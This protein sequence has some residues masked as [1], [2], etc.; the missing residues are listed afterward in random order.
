M[1]SRKHKKPDLDRREPIRAFGGV[2]G[3]SGEDRAARESSTKESS[4]K[5]AA[6]SS[7]TDP[8]SRG[9]DLGYRVIDQY[10]RQGQAFAQAGWPLGSKGAPAAADPQKLTERMYQYASDLASVW[11]EYA[12]TMGGQPPGVPAA[13]GAS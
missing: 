5:G 11:F 9:V 10:M 7:G 2:F 8:V 6:Q 4:G 12:Q 13:G 3:P 1:A